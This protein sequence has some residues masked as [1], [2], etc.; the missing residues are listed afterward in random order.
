MMYYIRTCVCT[1]SMY[2]YT[3]RTY[4]RTYMYSAYA[5]HS[6][7]QYVC[8]QNMQCIVCWLCRYFT[9]IG[10]GPDLVWS[11]IEGSKGRYVVAHNG[12]VMN[13]DPLKNFADPGSQVYF[14]RELVVWGDS[15]KLRYGKE[16]KDNPWL[17]EHMIRYTKISAWLFQGFRLDNCHNT[18]IVVAEVCMCVYI[19]TY[20]CA[21]VCTMYVCVCAC[22][23]ACVRACM[24]A[25]MCVC[26][27]VYAC[28]HVCVC[29]HACMLV[30]M[31]VCK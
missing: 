23:Y 26:V 3:V 19:R 5:A 27:C 7:I 4:V 11:E 12:W 2:I 28:V 17:W 20:V 22:V 15:V 16:P 9:V 21:Y 6:N 25:C 29:M 30:Q 8:T 31:G 14:Q 10:G 24:H 1:Y 13:A 18:P